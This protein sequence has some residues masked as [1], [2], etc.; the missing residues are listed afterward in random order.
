VHFTL[1]AF[2]ENADSVTRV[3]EM[4]NF[5]NQKHTATDSIFLAAAV[6][7]LGAKLRGKEGP[8]TLFK[9]TR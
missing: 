9:E 3:P 6:F 5:E 7:S 8:H 4:L 2:R 1:Q